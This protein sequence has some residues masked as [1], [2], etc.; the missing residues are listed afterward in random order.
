[1]ALGNCLSKVLACCF[2]FVFLLNQ[3]H[4]G[5]FRVMSPVDDLFGN[6]EYSALCNK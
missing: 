3:C 4:R 1:M 6:S 2:F 5:M